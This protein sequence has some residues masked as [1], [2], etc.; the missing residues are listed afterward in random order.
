M[1]ENQDSKKKI[2]DLMLCQEE[3]GTKELRE[4]E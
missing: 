1:K 3:L 4:K 2:K